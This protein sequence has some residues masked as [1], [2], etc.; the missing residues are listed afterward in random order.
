MSILLSFFLTSCH[1]Q[2]RLTEKYHLDNDGG[3]LET[4]EFVNDSTARLYYGAMGYEMTFTCQ[5][6]I[7]GK[8]LTITA[9]D[10]S[11]ISFA[12]ILRVKFNEARRKHLRC[13]LNNT[14]E[15]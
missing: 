5:Y 15:Y 2:N 7:N 12:G 3:M 13:L 6:S 11:T 9:Y 14:H 1:S 10:G 4:I 8:T